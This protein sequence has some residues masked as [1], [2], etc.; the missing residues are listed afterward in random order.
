MSAPAPN[1]DGRSSSA[2]S[3]SG[4]AVPTNRSSIRTPKRQRSTVSGSYEEK[5][6]D[7]LC[8]V[9]FDL[10][11]EAHITKCGHTF[12]YACI[13]KC[14]ETSKRCPKCNSVVVNEE[15]IFPNFLLN[16]LIKKHKLRLNGIEAL[17]RDSSGEFSC[18]ADGLRDFVASESQNLTLPDVNV[19]LEVLTQRKQL[20][21]AESCAAQNKLLLEFLRH[22]LKQ[23]REL[24]A[25][26]VKEVAV[27]ER[28]IEEVE[29]KLKEVQSK[30]P[31]LE[32]VERAVGSASDKDVATVT[33]IKKEMIGIIDNIESAVANKKEEEPSTSSSSKQTG[34]LSSLSTRRRRMHAHFDDFVQCY[35]AS[36]S[37]DLFFGKDDPNASKLNKPDS[38]SGLDEFRENLVKFSRYNAL[39]PVA[40]LNYS[41][42][43]FNNSTIVSSIEFDKDNEFFAIAGVTKR[44]KVFD[45]GAVVKDTVDIHYP[46]VE[47]VSSSKISCVSW[48]SYHKVSQCVIFFS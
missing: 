39:R 46:C 30:C 7:F 43:M 44:I 8:P 41:T 29:N 40:T 5:N 11:E 45:Y 12:C 42:D 38:T 36:R 37:K 31:T 14:I 20:L 48:N 9:C 19:I 34:G 3:H 25:R 32:D 4:S 35:F 33:A 13:T 15:S 21:E 6:A 18:S 22:L 28:D 26:I 1:R 27:I 10:I 23:K 47:M 24:K 16:D 2:S 17:N